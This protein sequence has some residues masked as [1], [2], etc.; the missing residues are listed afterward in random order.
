VNAYFFSW[1]AVGADNSALHPNAMIATCVTFFSDN[2]FADVF[3][4]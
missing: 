3:W 4:V 1:W 2:G